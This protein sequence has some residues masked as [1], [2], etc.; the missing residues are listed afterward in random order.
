M[1]NLSQI[2][3]L[4][5]LLRTKRWLS[6]EPKI[7]VDRPLL[8]ASL[9][10]PSSVTSGLRISVGTVRWLH[11]RGGCEINNENKFSGHSIFVSKSSVLRKRSSPK[12]PG[13]DNNS[14][15]HD[16]DVSI[17]LNK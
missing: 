11:P 12:H 3:Q 5:N 10:V 2:N 13:Q 8:L 4:Y 7:S 15:S 16:L 9:L 17:P 6:S 1:R 14:Y